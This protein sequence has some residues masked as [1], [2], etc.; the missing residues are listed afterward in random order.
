MS[1][2]APPTV[3]GLSDYLAGHSQSI[4]CYCECP[5]GRETHSDECQE[6]R[7]R[8]VGLRQKLVERGWVKR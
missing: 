7:D 1:K 6:A 5:D 3:G 2:H 8:I 4:P